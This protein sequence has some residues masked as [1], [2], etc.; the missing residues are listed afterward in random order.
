M[1]LLT[2]SLLLEHVGQHLRSILV[3][4]IQQVAWHRTFGDFLFIFL[5]RL[6]LFM[7]SDGLFHLD[8]LLE[9]FLVEQF[10]LDASQITRLLGQTLWLTSFLLSLALEIVH[11]IAMALA[12]EF[13]V[14]VLRHCEFGWVGLVGS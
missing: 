7:C 1:N 11:S 3:L 2:F 4:S 10:R 5:L 13:D 6:L 12:M 9:S 8:L 14:L